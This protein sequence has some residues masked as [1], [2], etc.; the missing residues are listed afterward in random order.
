MIVCCVAL[1]NVLIATERSRS[2]SKSEVVHYKFNAHS[3]RLQ[4]LDSIFDETNPGE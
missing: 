1:F 3:L 4:I 2:M